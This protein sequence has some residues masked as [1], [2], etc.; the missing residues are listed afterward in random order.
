[1]RNEDKIA[2]MKAEVEEITK[3]RVQ[4]KKDIYILETEVSVGA[5]FVSAGYYD[6]TNKLRI[7]SFDPESGV[8]CGEYETRLDGF[9]EV[10]RIVNED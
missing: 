5:V 8:I 9:S 1:M 7:T 4:L 2:A 3:R 6:D 10:W